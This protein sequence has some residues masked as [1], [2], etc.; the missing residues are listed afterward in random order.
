MHNPSGFVIVEEY[1]SGRSA[2]ISGESWM[3]ERRKT[4][5]FDGGLYTDGKM[6]KLEVQ[7][8]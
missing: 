3:V 5:K 6:Y 1:E 7:N 4:I 2:V 8:G